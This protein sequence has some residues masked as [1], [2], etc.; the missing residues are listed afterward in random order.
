MSLK[1]TQVKKFFVHLEELTISCRLLYEKEREGK[2]KSGEIVKHCMHDFWE[3]DLEQ[4]EDAYFNNK[5]I[6]G[7]E[8]LAANIMKSVNS[9]VRESG[10][11]VSSY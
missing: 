6:K 7:I 9:I 4:N 1:Y 5:C 10:E 3:C 2:R 8:K 11:H